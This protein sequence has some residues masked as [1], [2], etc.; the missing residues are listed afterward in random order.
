MRSR[1]GGMSALTVILELRIEHGQHLHNKTRFEQQ[2]IIE[3]YMQIVTSNKALL[4]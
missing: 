1:V 2:R 4:Q 3:K